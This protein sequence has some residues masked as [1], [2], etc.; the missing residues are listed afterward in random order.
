MGVAVVVFLNICLL[1]YG[2]YLNHA[3]ENIIAE[4]MS[5]RRLPLAGS[6]VKFRNMNSTVKMTLINF[7]SNEMTDVVAMIDGQV[8]KEFVEQNSRVEKGSPI[9]ELVNET[10]SLKIKQANS[11]ISEAEAVLTRAKNTYARYQQLIDQEAISLEKFDE[12]KA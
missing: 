11:D 10:I 6:E 1:S 7:Y 2:V 8:I 5:D 9:V 3:S 12:A 4:R